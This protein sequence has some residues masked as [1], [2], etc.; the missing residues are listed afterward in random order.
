MKS[1]FWQS[2]RQ[3]AEAHS[4]WEAEL[5]LNRALWSQKPMIYFHAPRTVLSRSHPATAQ[6]HGLGSP[7]L[8]SKLSDRSERLMLRSSS[9]LRAERLCH[10]WMGR[11][12]VTFHS[13]S[14]ACEPP[15]WLISSGPPLHNTQMFNFPWV[16]LMALLVPSLA[17]KFPIVL[18]SSQQ[19]ISV[20]ALDAH[21][22]SEPGTW[23]MW[24]V[25]DDNRS[26]SL[27]RTYLESG[28]KHFTD[29]F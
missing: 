4:H 16:I 15:G 7:S 1:W 19:D 27:L 29:I 2:L 14:A 10:L 21:W 8:G 28:F 18:W 13:P 24:H 23:I 26:E 5:G 17:P 22:E 12:S 6:T 9:D 25:W 11:P 3:L 20:L